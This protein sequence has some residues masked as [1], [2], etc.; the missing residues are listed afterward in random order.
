MIT[1]TIAPNTADFL[2][3]TTAN[4]TLSGYY[5]ETTTLTGLG[6]ATRT[7]TSAGSFKL[8]QIS[9]IATLTTQ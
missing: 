3:L 1:L 6:G 4:S 9:T 8:K 2:T 7:F 5:Q